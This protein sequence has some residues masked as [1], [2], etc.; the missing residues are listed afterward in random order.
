MGRPGLE[1]LATDGQDH[2]TENRVA[3]R[4]GLCVDSLAEGAAH[5][6]GGTVPGLAGEELGIGPVNVQTFYV[7]QP[8]ANLLFATPDPARSTFRSTL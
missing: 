4:S 2:G 8:I 1:T 5:S 3:V 7:T 6:G